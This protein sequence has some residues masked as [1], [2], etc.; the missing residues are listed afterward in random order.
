MSTTR[1]GTHD[2]AYRG[3][4][5]ERVADLNDEPVREGRYVL[6]W[7]QASQRTVL[8]HAL[9]Y[10]VHRAVELAQDAALLVT[11]LGYLRP[12]REWREN[13]A[14]DAP[15]RVVQVESDVVVPVPL[16]SDHRETAA[17]TLRPKILRHLDRFLVDLPQA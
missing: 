4:Q 15:C 12:Q 3:I 11:D 10:A 8:N 14:R 6:Y 2:D 5:Q 13:V 17:R 1:R 7:M 9:E 16:A